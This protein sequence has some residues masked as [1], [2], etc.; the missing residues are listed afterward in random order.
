MACIGLAVYGLHPSPANREAAELRLALSKNGSTKL[1]ISM[2]A[3]I[4]RKR[5]IAA[6]IGSLP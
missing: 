4:A 6:K 2:E 3:A 1:S 5:T